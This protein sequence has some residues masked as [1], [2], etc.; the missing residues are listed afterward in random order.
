MNRP[1]G[2]R[3]WEVVDTEASSIRSIF[4]TSHLPS[5]VWAPSPRR[6]HHRRRRAGAETTACD[7]APDSSRTAARRPD[8]AGTLGWSE[9]RLSAVIGEGLGTTFYALLNRYR[10]G[11]FERLARDPELRHRSVLELAYEAGF[12]S[13]ASFYRVFRES[14]GT[15][16]TAF[17][18]AI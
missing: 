6:A 17:R 16:P 9:N 15:T 10:L 12:N 11:E 1:G 4:E 3:R 8:L 7:H 5:P 2:I 18:K 13:K 14:H